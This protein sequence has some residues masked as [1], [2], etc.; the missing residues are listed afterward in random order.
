M[1]LICNAIDI[2]K[3]A[4][5]SSNLLNSYTEQIIE[6]FENKEGKKYIILD[7]KN[8][9]LL[10]KIKDILQKNSYQITLIEVKVQNRFVYTNPSALLKVIDKEKPLPSK[11][12]CETKE[13]EIQI[14]TPEQ[15]LNKTKKEIYISIQNNTPKNI[16]ID[17]NITSLKILEDNCADKK[18]KA[19]YFGYPMN[20]II[21]EEDFDKEIEI[22][23]DLIQIYT[24]KNCMLH[25]L[26][27]IIEN[28]K[29]ETCGRCVY[30]YEGL[31]Q[32]SMTLS[33]IEQKK[34][35]TA[36]LE[37]ILNLCQLMKSQT[38]C[39]IGES[40]A[41]IVSETI[42]KFT[43]EIE[44]HITKRNCKAEFCSKFVT[45]HILQDLCTGCDECECEED[46]II[47][48]KR[49]VHI[50]VQDECTQCGKCVETCEEEAIVKAG[51]I[52]PRC[53]K[54]PIPVKRK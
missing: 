40:I 2:Y 34:G 37:Q 36:D 15:L 26:N 45:Y 49:F 20:R 22:T 16:E 44:E 4:P 46:A 38:I 30:G 23:T 42:N 29:Q 50:I 10:K 18:C 28:Y 47:G 11:K 53:P 25:E 51:T 48:R 17:Y 52:K 27:Q 3:Q 54:K 13:T 33:D 31:T 12:K 6:A 7:N 39:E 14:Y 19:I 35:K 21:T 43:S 9:S 32:I 5:V 41:N 1:N 8:Q 24:D